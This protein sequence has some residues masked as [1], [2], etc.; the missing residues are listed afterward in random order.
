HQVGLTARANPSAAHG[1][2]SRA[3]FC[4]CILLTLLRFAQVHRHA[5]AKLLKLF[6]I[7]GDARWHDP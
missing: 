5:S 3:G 6:G 1:L 7:L 2:G 4:A